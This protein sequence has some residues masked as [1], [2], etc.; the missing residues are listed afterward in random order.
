MRGVRRVDLNH[1][2]GIIKK[3]LKCQPNFGRGWRKGV[4]GG[5]GAT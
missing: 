5:G 4:E 2:R 1:Q 3:Q